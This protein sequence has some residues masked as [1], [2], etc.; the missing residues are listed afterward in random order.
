MTKASISAEQ[1]EN[2]QKAFCRE[3]AALYSATPGDIKTG[4]ALSTKGRVPINGLR[5]PP[6]GETSGWY[7]WCGQE[8]SDAAD[9]FDPLHTRHLYAEYPDLMKL[10]GLPPG[11]RFLLA[12]D[13]LD[14]WYDASLLNVQQLRRNPF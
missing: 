13:Y 3:Q 10:L 7:I 8:L 11:Y 1:I 14:V 4:F 9:F 5:H 2:I 12:D 6:E